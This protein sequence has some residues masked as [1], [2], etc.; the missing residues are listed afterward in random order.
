LAQPQRGGTTSVV[1][2]RL[3]LQRS[4]HKEWRVASA[5]LRAMP[6]FVIIGAQRGGTTSLYDWLTSHPDVLPASQKEL[7]FFDGKNY[8]R[9]MR[10]YRSRFPIA[11]KGKITGESTPHMLYNPLSPRR[12]AALLPP[13]TRFIV[14]L[15]DPVERAIS[16][17]WLSRRS[18][19]ETEDLATAI[20][21]ETRRLAPEQDAFLNGR[22]SY[23]HHKFSYVARGAYASQ[24]QR[25]FA[26]VDRARILVL[27]SELLFED[28]HELEKLTDWLGLAALPGPLPALNAAQRTETD[29]A[30]VASLQEHFH[31]ENEQLF[32]FLGR[33]LW[34]R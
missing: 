34:V 3:R 18:G 7:H 12:A 23:A 27:E 24:L 20:S 4:A 33:R 16:H 9:G 14:L 6:S 17:Y 32:A 25:W 10:W 1:K 11:R 13:T 8:N 31:P 29:P 19:A 28:I 22:Y 21:L 30:V 2:I 15:R 5:G 26:D